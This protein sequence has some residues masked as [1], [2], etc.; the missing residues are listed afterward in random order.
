LYHCGFQ[1]GYQM[2][3]NGV[4]S[5]VQNLLIPC[6]PEPTSTYTGDKHSFHGGDAAHTVKRIWPNQA[7]YSDQCQVVWQT[8]DNKM[9]GCGYNAHGQ[10]AT[11]NST[12]SQTATEMMGHASNTTTPVVRWV[13][14]GSNRSDTGSYPN[15]MFLRTDGTVWSGGWQSDSYTQRGHGNL[16][17]T[18]YSPTLVHMPN[19]VQG[20]IIDVYSGGHSYY[21]CDYALHSD[22]TIYGWSYAASY[23]MGSDE[24][25]TLRKTAGVVRA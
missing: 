16:A 10:M 19:G 15:Y 12:H 3:N 24:V 13:W 7:Y 8:E 11:G 2:G 6:Q 22:G 14:K 17:S 9:W 1:G 18:E 20:N 21:T 25:A 4:N 5:G 23:A